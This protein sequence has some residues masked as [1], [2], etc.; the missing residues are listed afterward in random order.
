MSKATVKFGAEDTNLSSTL[1]KV[2]KHLERLE[3]QS[4]ETSERFG[5]SFKSMA[6]AGAGLA[7]GI[8]A[9]KLAFNVAKGTIDSFGEALDMGGRL[10]DLAGRTGESAGNMLLLER[11]F[12]NAGSSAEKV[13][14]TINKLQKFIVDAGDSASSQRKAITELGLSYADLINKSPTDQLEAIANAISGVDNDAKRGALAVQV[15][16]KSGGELLPFLRDFS[17]SLGGA[18]YELGSMAKVMDRSSELFDQISDNLTV[19]K[20]KTVEVAAG[21][22]EKATPAIASFTNMLAGIDGASWGSKLMDSVLRVSDVMTGVFLQ[23][24]AAVNAIGS[25]LSAYFRN[26]GNLYLNGL[27]TGGKYLAAFWTSEIPS[28]ILNIVSSSLQKAYA[29]SAKFFIDTMLGAAKNIEQTLVKAVSGVI[30]FTVISLG[31]VV[32]MLASD[33]GQALTNPLNY[34]AG[35]IT[36]LLTGAAESGG[37]TFESAFTDSVNTS[38]GKLS[39]G[40]GEVSKEYGQSIKDSVKDVGS[41]IGKI[42]EIVDSSDKD[43]FGA[44]DATAQMKKDFAEI[45]ATGK[46]FRDSLSGGYDMRQDIKELPQ[47]GFNMAN[48]LKTGATAMEKAAKTVKETLS[49]SEEIMKR[50]A[51]FQ[52]KEKVDPGGKLS[53][54]ADEALSSGNVKKAERISKQIE[55]REQNQAIREKFGEKQG[56]RVNKSLRDIAKEQGVDTFRKSNEQIRKELLEKEGKG[57]GGFEKDPGREKIKEQDIKNDQIMTGIKN[58]V[59]AIKK[60]VEKIEPKLPQRA[61]AP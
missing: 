3:N 28:L 41:E 16:G 22:I 24:M 59:E 20:G 2:Q 50:I 12:S 37:V 7:I 26:A 6:A 13:G 14:P 23:P 11:A 54:K 36:S 44:K 49:L 60:A 29:D 39:K 27:I 17:G 52:N 43:F 33:L 42:V 38:L 53:K 35:K 47:L 21:F 46:K 34:A 15:F 4:K 25:A 51:D 31:E 55:E 32:K 19:I 8:G 5:V 30:R 9:I 45:E 57:K 10:N 48:H 61:L 58:A 56:S 40:L 18:K 1:N